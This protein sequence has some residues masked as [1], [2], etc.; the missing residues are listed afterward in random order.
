MQMMRKREVRESLVV[1][2]EEVLEETASRV[3]VGDKKRGSFWTERWVRQGYPLS[4]CLFTLLLADLD[5]KLE[6]K[7]YGGVKIKERKIYSM[8][9]A[10]NVA[11][12]AEEEVGMKEMMI[13]M[14][15]RYVERKGLEVN[16]EETKVMRCKK[17]V[18]GTRR[19]CR[20]GKGKK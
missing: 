7:R 9:Y 12:V 19:W 15:E 18:G 11:V 20:N 1:R 13:K 10:D 17:R 3:R 5:E 4:L 16:V 2:C 8:A 14:L 6:K